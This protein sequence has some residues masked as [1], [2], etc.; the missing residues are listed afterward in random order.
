MLSIYMLKRNPVPKTHRVAVFYGRVIMILAFVAI[1]GAGAFGVRR[2]L[3]ETT[4]SSE[5]ESS[6]TARLL[7]GGWLGRLVTTTMG[8]IG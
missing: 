7:T 5:E 8:G 6:G 1:F 2:M 4:T 3:E